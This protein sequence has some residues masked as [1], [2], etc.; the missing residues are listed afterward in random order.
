MELTPALL[1]ALVARLFSPE[2]QAEAAR[3]LAQYGTQPHEREEIRVRVAA[4]KLSEGSLERL[5]D[6]IAHAR[7]DY[8]DV[9]GWAEYPE[10]MRSLT[11]RLPR[12]EQVRIRAADRGQYLAWLAAHGA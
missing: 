2:A 9:L 12:A 1:E 3:V 8:R 4:L 5:R 11:W 10:E 7:R 6:L